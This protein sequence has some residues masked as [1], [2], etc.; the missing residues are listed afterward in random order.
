NFGSFEYV[1]KAIPANT[2][3][4]T[5]TKIFRTGGWFSQEDQIPGRIYFDMSKPSD[6]GGSARPRY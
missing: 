3:L 4:F 2:N 5:Q 6:I 1:I